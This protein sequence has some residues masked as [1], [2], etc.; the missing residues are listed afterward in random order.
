MLD[1]EGD[2]SVV[3]IVEGEVEHFTVDAVR[4]GPSCIMCRAFTSTLLIP[5]HKT[6]GYSF[7][8]WECKVRSRE[9]RQKVV[10]NKSSASRRVEVYRERIGGVWRNETEDS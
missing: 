4:V 7:G 3:Q 9:F 5:T 6:D 2:A 1:C 8:L 10:V